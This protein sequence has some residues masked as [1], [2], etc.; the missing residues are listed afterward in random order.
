V[1]NSGGEKNMVF[2]CVKGMFE[3]VKN[4]REAFNLEAFQSKYLEEY[5][6]K[7]MYIVGDISSEILRLK[8]F[9]TDPKSDNY[10]GFI[11]DYLEISCAF[12]CPYYVLKRIKNEDEY[13]RLEKEGKPVD[14][15]DDR[16][17]IHPM[18]K[19]NFDKESLVLKPSQK[20]KPNIV[21][22]PRKINSIPKG[23]LPKDLVDDNDSKDQNKKGNKEIE[24]KVVTQTF[25]SASEGFD[26]SKMKDRRRPDMKDKKKNPKE[27]KPKQF[28]NNN[29]P[30]GDNRV[31]NDSSD[32][33]QKENFN[34][35]KNHYKKNK[36]FNGNRQDKGKDK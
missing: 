9:N 30:K 17:T 23:E 4:Y 21:I 6:D 36:N 2:K 16:I 18:T 12:G 5:F 7:D 8:G 33:K 15:E 29:K 3:L 1:Y 11:E 27:N 31:K 34:R 28:N 10:Y 22:D 19:E 24:E 35:N 26:P 13:R 14:T 32:D 25:V 20:G